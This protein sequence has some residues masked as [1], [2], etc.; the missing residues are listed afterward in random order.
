MMRPVHAFYRAGRCLLLFVGTTAD[1]NVSRPFQVGDL[2]LYLATSRVFVFIVDG[3]ATALLCQLDN[4][5]PVELA[6]LY[7]GH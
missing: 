1:D 7:Q 3:A 2:M 5:F 6:V 4:L